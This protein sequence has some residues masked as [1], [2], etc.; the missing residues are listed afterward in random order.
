LFVFLKERKRSHGVR[1]VGRILEEMR[2][3]N[4]NGTGK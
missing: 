2:E 4:H 1:R 3:K